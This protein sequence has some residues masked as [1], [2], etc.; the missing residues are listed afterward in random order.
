MKNKTT[1]LPANGATTFFIIAAALLLSLDACAQYFANTRQ[2]HEKNQHDSNFPARKKFNAGIMATYTNIA[3]PPAVIADATYGLNNRLSF[4]V[5]AGSTGTQSL[6]G[7]K[8]NAVLI[9]KNDFRMLYRMVIVYYP[10]RKGEY[11]FDHTEKRIIPW[12]LSMAALDAEWKTSKGIR[13]SIGM[14]VLETHCIIG[15]KRFFW[16]SGDEKKIMPFEFFHTLQGSVSIPV[17]RRLTFRPEVIAVM[18]DAK[19]I[20]TGDFKVFPINPFLKLIYTFR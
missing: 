18:K 4:G 10:G 9:E 2:D 14:G 11:L 20:R 17:S 7:L 6:A 3:P 13:W 15:M 1:C 19:L 8:F 5:M 12:M 16:G